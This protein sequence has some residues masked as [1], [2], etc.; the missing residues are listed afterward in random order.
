MQSCHSLQTYLT[1]PC[2][3]PPVVRF[4]VGMQR[5]TSSPHALPDYAILSSSHAFCL[6]SGCPSFG[7]RQKALQ[8]WQH[9]RWHG[10]PG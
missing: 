7:E 6:P 1:P 5:C 2:T 3:C 9:M 10:R 8:L 4:S